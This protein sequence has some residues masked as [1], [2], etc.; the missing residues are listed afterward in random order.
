[1]ISLHQSRKRDGCGGHAVH[2][3]HTCFGRQT[4][5]CWPRLRCRSLDEEP[6]Q[7]VEKLNQCYLESNTVRV[8]RGR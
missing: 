3:K 4:N 5:V 1:M 2:T 8:G 7:C 6:D